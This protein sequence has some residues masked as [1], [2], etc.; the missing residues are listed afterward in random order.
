MKRHTYCCKLDQPFDILG[1][2]RSDRNSTQHR[3]LEVSLAPHVVQV[4]ENRDHV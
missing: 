1:T 4:A 3:S 2:G